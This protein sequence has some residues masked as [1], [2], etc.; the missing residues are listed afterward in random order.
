MSIVFDE[1]KFEEL[2][3]LAWSILDKAKMWYSVNPDIMNK[4]GGH[5]SENIAGVDGYVH[6][7]VVFVGKEDGDEQE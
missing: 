7:C 1:K 3:A 2:S 4:I 6:C 5:C